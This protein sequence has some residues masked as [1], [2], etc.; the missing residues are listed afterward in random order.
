MG[1]HLG[2]V[3]LIVADLDRAISFYTA[4]LDLTVTERLANYAFLSFGDHHHDLALQE[5][6]EAES[7]VADSRLYHVA[8]E[9]DSAAALGDAARWLNDEGIAVDPVDHGISKALYFD[10]PDGNGV[11]LY[12]DTRDDGSEQWHGNN[13][14]F[15]PT[16]L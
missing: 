3:H 9:L 10:D 5:R 16:A 1:A 8:F 12:V 4:L 13:A 14:R 15:D 7:S 2:H 6:A 11:E